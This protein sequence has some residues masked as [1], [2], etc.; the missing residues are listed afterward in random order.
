[1][2]RAIVNISPAP[3]AFGS[4]TNVYTTLMAA[5]TRVAIIMITNTLDQTVTL[6]LDGGTTD[7]CQLGA[8][9]GWIIDFSAAGGQYDGAISIKY[10]S[11]A[12]AAGFIQAVPVGLQ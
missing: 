3:V 4:V 9:Q 11:V 12:P 1:M 10:T 2:R 6:S 5:K 8:G 7:F